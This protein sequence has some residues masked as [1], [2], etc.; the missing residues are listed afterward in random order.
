[1]LVATDRDDHDE[2][3]H[4]MLV[5]L[6]PVVEESPTRRTSHQQLLPLGILRKE[7]VGYTELYDVPEQLRL[8]LAVT[9]SYLVQV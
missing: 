8:Q 4:A 3:V 1:M 5:V 9:N 7:Q 6:A 2:Q